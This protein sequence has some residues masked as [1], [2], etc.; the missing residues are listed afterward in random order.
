[1]AVES[2]VLE[3][4]PTQTLPIEHD[5]AE[6]RKEHL[7]LDPR[8]REEMNRMVLEAMTTT[9]K[10]Y[11]I[12]V[13]VLAVLV[14]VLL[15]GAWGNQI[16]VGMGVTGKRRPVFWALY[17]TTFVF[18]IG[19]SHA[20]TFV[21]AILRVFKAEFR[22]PFTRAAELMTTFGLASGALFPLI[23]L[24][25]VWVFYWM[26]PYP[27]GRWL[28]PNFRSPLVW[29][30]LAIT[31][32][33]LSSTIYLYLPLIPD[34]AM[35]R[36]RTSGWRHSLYRLLA[37]GWRG[38][39]AEW[40]RLRTAIGIFAFAIIPVMFSVHTIVS[41]D[42][43][44]SQ[45]VGWSSTIFGPYFIIGAI[46]SGVSAVVTILVVLQRTLKNMDYFIRPE[47]LDALGKL[48]LIFSMAWAY[49]FFN[50]YMIAWYGGTQALK[51]LIT[52][53]A[54]GPAAWVW[55]VMLIC[56]VAIPWLTLWNRKIRRTPWAMLAITLLINVGMYA[57]R[58]TIIPLTLGH[59]RSP[60]D[61]GEYTPR[62]TDISIVVGT[63]CLFILLYLLASRVLPLVPVWEVQEG[64]VAH[65]LR[66]VG[67]T[68]VPSVTELE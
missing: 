67:K 59:Q 50:D 25:R 61:W 24:G 11:W 15:F 20:G 18:W 40:H 36:D 62:L 46:L 51:D 48:I 12:A 21:S 54:S 63:F 34:V 43:A 22:R 49:F 30:F 65:S 23:H 32:Y 37:L 28:W 31:T 5:E 6:E 29:D 3:Q 26:I 60:F 53:H 14:A 7:M 44:V 17:I 13:G 55:Y 9:S 2:K 42:F 19:I 64:Q 1:M 58:Y 57:E 33:L 10:R 45:T 8:R 16:L 4:A 38:T 68:K 66:K 27:N 56:N 47:H 35:A 39:E 52:M 41:W